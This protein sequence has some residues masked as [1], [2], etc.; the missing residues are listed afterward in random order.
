LK[1]DDSSLTR[2]EYARVRKEAERMLAEAG[3]LGRFPT[4]IPDIL[5][6]A[7]VEVAPSNALDENL[8]DWIR[9][10]AG[11]ASANLKRALGKVIGLFDSK[12]RLIFIDHA[13]LPV[14]QT[15]IKLHETGH[16]VLPWQKDI[17]G[18]IE[19]CK[20][21]LA[22]E[23]S[24]LFDREANVFA[25]EVLFQ[26]DGFSKEAA[27]FKFGINV[28]IRLSKKYG[29]SI[30]ASIR[31]YVSKNPRDCLVL[32]LDQPVIITGDGFTSTLRR[33][34][35]SPTFQKRIGTL[36]WPNIFTPSDEIGAMIPV[37]GRKMSGNR[38]I[39]IKDRDGNRHNCIAEAFTQGHQVFILI[40]LVQTLT[41]TT[42]I[43][44]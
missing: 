24:D 15:F 44:P 19:D 37:G 26:V 43:L 4:S 21:T 25:S 40:H 29:A 7:K 10:K 41:K 38:E 31:Q 11:T 22:S 35:S 2:E 3:A 27:D 33:V 42:V 36:P 5:S 39:Q 32:V 12:S 16:A 14:K 18:V 34:I 6:A 13:V 28:P 30:Y 8:L 1:P 20:L 9:K 23:V 17:Y